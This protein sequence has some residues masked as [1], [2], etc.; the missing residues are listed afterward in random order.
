MDVKGEARGRLPRELAGLG[1]CALAAT[2]ILMIC[3]TNSF[4]YPLNPWVDVNCF[5]TVTRG[6][7]NGLL[8]YRDLMEQ[9]GP[10]IYLIHAIGLVFSPGNY[11]GFFLLE[12][13]CMT[14]A[15]WLSWR[16]I[17][18]CAPGANAVWAALPL[19]VMCSVKGF[20][21]GDLAEE[22]CLPLALASMYAA[23]KHWRSGIGL[24]LKV[25]L[26]HGFLAGCV[27]WIKFNQLGTHFAF[28]AALAVEAV[29]EDRNPV[30]A[31]KMCGA[32]LAGILLASVPWLVYFAAAGALSDLI[33]VYFVGNLFGYTL[34]GG[35]V[36]SRIII[37]L[38]ANALRRKPLAQKLGV[39]A[40]AE[41]AA[42]RRLMGWK[43]KAFLALAAAS[44]LTLVYGGGR[45]FTYYIEGLA[46]LAVFGALPPA[47]LAMWAKKRIGKTAA[48]R[49]ASAV[50]A[51]A[52]LVGSIGLAYTGFRYRWLMRMRYE[53]TVQG[54]FGA[55]IRQQ[56]DRTLLNFGSLDG[57]FYFAADTLPVNRWFCALNYG[58]AEAAAEQCQIVSE[59]RVHFVAT[60]NYSLERFAEKL[61]EI[62]QPLDISG[63]RLVMQE[64][65][66]Y[67]YQ[68]AEPGAL[69]A[70]ENGEEPQA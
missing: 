54:K 37:G 30:R 24:S 22:W 65:K 7:M 12:V 58:M 27:L 42:P 26:L 68:R 1:I 56:E 16:I 46:P 64:G 39:G 21:Y 13:V 4:L 19:A 40:I 53:D 52:V 11:H 57:G 31:L 20:V 8:P 45:H 14:W 51:A 17:R 61:G 62:G 60:Q 28:M 55:Y 69:P 5:V 66:Y 9:K 70:P 48:I 25:F 36:P 2:A 41:L 34:Q 23:L 29:L 50:A 15:A 35:S 3:S 18:L 10:L 49:A 33:G 32:F 47:W 38:C 43:E 63:Y 6:W 44:V 67:L 59:G